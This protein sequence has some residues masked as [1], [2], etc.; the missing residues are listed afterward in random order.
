MIRRIWQQ[1]LWLRFVLFQRHRYR[2]L[3]LEWVG[4]K[5]FVVL[6]DV[7]NPGIFRTGEFLAQQFKNHIPPGSSAL[8]M[9]TG[10]GIGAVFAAQFARQVT[11]VDINPEAVRNVQINALLNRV[12]GRVCARESDVFSALEGE[13]FDVILFNPPFFRGKPKDLEDYAWRSVDVIER[14][15]AG[16]DDHL[17]PGGFALVILSSLGETPAFLKAFE[18]H[19]LQIDVLA[20][21][22]VLSEILTVY[23]VMPN[24]DS[25]DR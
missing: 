1:I 22:D 14:F 18:A 6:P 5:P 10:S 15:A 25:P 13:R 17:N 23:R 4:G 9:G 2:C 16:L 12:E 8:D 3:A 20:K 19:A 21:Q 24:P 11:A 7:F